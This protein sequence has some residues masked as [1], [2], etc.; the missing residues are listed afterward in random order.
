MTI[1]NDYLFPIQNYNLLKKGFNTLNI[2][3]KKIEAL[4]FYI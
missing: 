2:K 4:F 1:T 3:K